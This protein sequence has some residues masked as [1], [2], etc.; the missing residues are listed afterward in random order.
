MVQLGEG[1][2]FIIKSAFSIGAHHSRFAF[3]GLWDGV[4]RMGCVG[5]L[6]GER[7]FRNLSGEI[8]IQSFCSKYGRYNWNQPP[9]RLNLNWLFPNRAPTI[10]ETPNALLH[11]PL[12]ALKN[13]CQTILINSRMSHKLPHIVETSIQSPIVVYNR[14]IRLLSNTAVCY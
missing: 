5:G 3:M 10:K 2:R 9:L 7:L 1:F 4:F 12:F 8:T 6:K 11:F 13:V 14:L